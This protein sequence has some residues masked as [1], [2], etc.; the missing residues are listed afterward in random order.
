MALGKLCGKARANSLTQVE[1]S[2]IAKRAA[3]ARNLK[4][5]A[6]ERGRIANLAVQARE[7]KRRLKGKENWRRRKRQQSG[8]IFKARGSWY[9]RYFE[10]RVIDGQLRHNRIAKQIE[11]G[12]H[13]WKTSTPD[14]RRRG[15]GDRRRCNR[16]QRDPHRV[17][18]IGEFVMRVY[19]PHIEQFKRPSTLRG[20]RDIWENPVKARC[21]GDWLKD[22]RTFHVQNWLDSI[23]SLGTLSRNDL[24]RRRVHG[25]PAGRDTRLRREDYG[26]DQIRVSRAIWEGHVNDPNTGVAKRRTSN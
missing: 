20:Y 19:F 8:S 2:A 7:R 10:D 3:A 13:S 9:V 21:A 25:S 23:A 15:A 26:D 17:P 4:L 18:N 12:H 6:A 24:R 1:R 11:P 5:S 16:H 22:F 14:D